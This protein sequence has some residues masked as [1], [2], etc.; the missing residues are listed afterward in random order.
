[1]GGKVKGSSAKSRQSTPLYYLTGRSPCGDSATL[2]D[3]QYTIQL[4]PGSTTGPEREEDPQDE[5]VKQ[6]DQIERDKP[7]KKGRAA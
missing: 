3:C 4:W 2:F 1:M 6:E 7:G 5:D